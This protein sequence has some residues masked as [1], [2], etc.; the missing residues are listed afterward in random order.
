MS[1][2]S[3]WY[4]LIIPLTGLLIAGIFILSAYEP[5]QNFIKTAVFFGT[6]TTSLI[7]IG[8]ILIVMYL[9]KHFPWETNPYKHLAIEFVLITTYTLLVIYLL[10]WLS[11]EGFYHYEHEN[12]GREIFMTLLITY[13]ITAIHESV[14]FYK[15]WKL[16]FS[17]SARL[18][19]DNIAA[20]YEAL[21]NQ[22]NPHFL[23]NSLN[24]LSSISGDN[25]E[26]VE[27]IRNLSEMLRY[28][29][30][31]NEK[32]LVLLRDEIEV[33]ENYIRLQK[34]RFGA[35]LQIEPNIPETHYHF[36]LPPLS[37]Q[38]LVENAIKH[39]IVTSE[40]PLKINL[41]IENETLFVANNLQ[42]K[43]VTDSTGKGLKN[44]RGRYTLFTTR[45]LIIEKTTDSFKVGLPLLKVSL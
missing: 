1:I 45:Q 33:L 8:C 37:L 18:E 36:A 41:W 28:M 2:K 31:S 7:W 40:Q 19:R 15:Q 14:F 22:V 6:L 35:K 34:M 21:R 30:N 43:K 42:L 4:Y 12:T 39:N 26:A 16:N 29:L 23:F 10:Y 24:S 38:M 11:L 3:N 27:Y 20:R 13:L 5:N 44:I 17:K 32:E 9:W 25:R